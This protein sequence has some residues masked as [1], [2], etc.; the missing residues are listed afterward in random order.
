MLFSVDIRN[1][2]SDA[3]LKDYDINHDVLGKENENQL[4]VDS[5]KLR[6]YIELNMVISH[7]VN[8]RQKKILIPFINCASDDFSRLP[9]KQDIKAIEGR[10]CPD[11]KKAKQHA[12]VKG[13]YGNQ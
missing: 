1:A 12:R 11:Y 5:N 8:G 4:V 13:L 7:K 6:N 9:N 10:L 2:G 3:D